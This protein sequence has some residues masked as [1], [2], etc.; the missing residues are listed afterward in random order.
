MAS[1]NGVSF[2]FFLP[3][4]L[5]LSR[6]SFTL[7]L[8]LPHFRLH[9]FLYSRR[10]QQFLFRIIDFLYLHGYNPF[11]P[12][13]LFAFTLCDFVC[14]RREGTAR[15]TMHR[16]IA[17]IF[18]FFHFFHLGIWRFERM[19]KQQKRHH[20]KLIPHYTHFWMLL[21]FFFSFSSQWWWRKEVN[22]RNVLFLHPFFVVLRSV[23]FMCV[24]LSPMA[25]NLF[26][27]WLSL[28]Q[29]SSLFASVVFFAT[30]LGILISS[31]N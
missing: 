25:P 10:L 24:C 3:S 7:C 27:G 18:F 13:L 31:F 26:V 4:P 20:A 17:G 8:F 1:S 28:V 23:L 30:C 16:H 12:Y 21:Q 11:T 14:A 2:P 15:A 22:G 6:A 29:L 5:I 9:W 19:K